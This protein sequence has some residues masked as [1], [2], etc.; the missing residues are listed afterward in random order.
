MEEPVGRLVHLAASER[1]P[2]GEV[3]HPFFIPQAK[4]LFRVGR[5]TRPAPAD[6]AQARARHLHHLRASRPDY[7]EA[8]DTDL[9][10]DFAP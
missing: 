4:H 7:G 6:L 8:T 1:F 3:V 10:E 5:I 2:A 9:L